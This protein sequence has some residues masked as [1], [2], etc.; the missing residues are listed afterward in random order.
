MKKLLLIPVLALGLTACNDSDAPQAT[1][2]NNKPQLYISLSTSEKPAI[3]STNNFGF[4][5]FSSISNDAGDENVFFS[6]LVS[7]LNLSLIANA[8]AGETRSE[9]L[10][11]LGVNE[12][13][14]SD[15]N[16][17]MKKLATAL[18][19]ADNKTNLTLASSIW[20]SDKCNPTAA[21]KNT[22]ID[23]YKA[24][25]TTY[26]F[27]SPTIASEINK[28]CSNKTNG[29]IR[30]LVSQEEMT[31]STFAIVNATTFSS[32]WTWKFSGDTVE[33]TFHTTNRGDCKAQMMYDKA[34]SVIATTD[35]LSM[36]TK[37]FG[38]RSFYIA[39]LLPHENVALDEAIQSLDAD[40]WHNLFY[41]DQRKAYDITLVV[42][43]LDFRTEYDM[44]PHYSDLGIR[45]AISSFAD[46]SELGTSSALTLSRQK[47]QFKMD[48]KGAEAVVS[49]ISVGSL[50]ISGPMPDWSEK[51]EFRLDRPF[52][53]V[54]YESSTKAIIF[55]GKVEKP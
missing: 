46:F 36:L 20:L 4:R 29:T 51:K 5:L 2:D 7:S 55:A 50:G 16:T 37:P 43:K 10:T 30:Q 19:D 25:I 26:P 33:E 22:C 32:E 8:A 54:I 12:S 15:L 18:P 17:A 34:E 49:N 31:S 24:D 39:F 6:P 38:N 44:I 9:I 27:G 23:T 28:W 21:F 52:A 40:T 1:T 41:G 35:K 45:S 13:Q 47:A 42:P 53:F 3:A 48:E 14:I 11:A